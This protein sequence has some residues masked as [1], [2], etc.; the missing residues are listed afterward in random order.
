MDYYGKLENMGRNNKEIKTWPVYEFLK[1]KWTLY[2]IVIP[3]ALSLTEECIRPR[4]WNDIRFE[5][6]EEF[7]EDSEDFN[8][9]RVFELKL[10]KHENFI[11]ELTTAARA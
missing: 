1:Q 5:V 11:D 2:R 9:E 8:L 4:H 10:D 3:I 6:K 7:N